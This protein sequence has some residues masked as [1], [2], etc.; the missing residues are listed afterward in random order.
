MILDVFLTTDSYL[1]VPALCRDGDYAVAFHPHLISVPRASHQMKE[2]L[3]LNALKPKLVQIIFKNSVH[4]AKKN[5]TS[6]LQRST[7]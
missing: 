3:S 6:P 2:Y 5:N 1:N 7:G 4:T